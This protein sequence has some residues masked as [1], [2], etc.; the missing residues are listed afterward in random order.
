M[1]DETTTYYI[2]SIYYYD[3]CNWNQIKIIIY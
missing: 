1:T 2:Q 3:Y